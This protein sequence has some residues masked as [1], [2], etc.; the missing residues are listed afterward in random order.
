MT[1][2]SGS[3]ARRA[4]MSSSRRAVHPAFRSMRRI[5]FT[6]RHAT[7]R[8]RPRT[9]TGSSPK[10][11]EGLIIPICRSALA[12]LLLG[13]AAVLPLQPAAATVDEQSALAAYVRAR[14]A[15]SIGAYDQAV[16]DYRAALALSP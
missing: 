5:A 9:S 6:A 8:T 10:A 2:P 13:A 11:E 12:A 4:F 15:D 3:T 16:R 14:A 1:G 7:S